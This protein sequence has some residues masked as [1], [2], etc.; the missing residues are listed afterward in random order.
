M[1]LEQDESLDVLT[2][3][4]IDIAPVSSGVPQG[5]VP[6]PIL[7]VTFINEMPEAVNSKA[8]LFADD[9]PGDGECRRLWQTAVRPT[10]TGAMGKDVGH[11]I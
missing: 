10:S 2:S 11:V 9:V 4:P 3:R 6:G 8:R 5:S 7:L 1:P